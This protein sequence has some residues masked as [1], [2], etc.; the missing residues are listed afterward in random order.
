M[1]GIIH[2][3][4]IPQSLKFSDYCVPAVL[5]TVEMISH[6]IPSHIFSVSSSGFAPRVYLCSSGLLETAINKIGVMKYFPVA[7]KNWYNLIRS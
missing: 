2:L 3:I 6:Y 4:I 7:G 1:K 5:S